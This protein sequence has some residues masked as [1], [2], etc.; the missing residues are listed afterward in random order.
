MTNTGNFTSNF[1]ATNFQAQPWPTSASENGFT[2]PPMPATP[3]GPLTPN[4]PG[5]NSDGVYVGMPGDYYFDHVPYA[6]SFVAHRD[7]KKQYNHGHR[8]GPSWLPA[9]EI[10]LVDNL[11]KEWYGEPWPG[12]QGWD[13][14]TLDVPALEAIPL[15]KKEMPPFKINYDTYA[16]IK[17]RLL[18]TAIS[19]KGHPFYVKHLR[20]TE[21]GKFHLALSD[22]NKMYQAA[23]DDLTDLR[24]MPPMYVTH[25]GSAGWLCR[26]PGRI[27]QQGMN[28]SNTQLRSPDGAAAICSME[29]SSIVKAVRGRQIRKWNETMFS[30][31]SGG[32]ISN[33][34]LTDEVAVRSRNN[35]IV[36]CFRGRPLGA[37]K[38]NEVK[39]YDED[40]LLQEWIE[41]PV[42]EAGLELS[43]A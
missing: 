4:E 29:A 3:G 39:V 6:T 1:F 31:M 42:R 18:G 5:Y 34:R 43:A 35:K 32:E 25:S 17:L 38:G 13:F 27:Y 14:E 24:S 30:L 8:P 9:D 41:N 40:D 12:P 21:N 28:R 37:I 10:K 26:S 15:R 7:M 16:E 22:G 33:L 19:V 36:A 20:K 23:Y 11:W 2:I